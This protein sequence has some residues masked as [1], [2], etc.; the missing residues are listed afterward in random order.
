[1]K[2]ALNER[3]NEIIKSFDDMLKNESARNR[4]YK[5]KEVRAEL[6]RTVAY[7]ERL[8]SMLAK[9]NNETVA[10]G[11][12]QL[13]IKDQQEQFALTEEMYDTVRRRIQE[14]EVERKRPAQISVAY[15]A[16][17]MLAK[18]QRF[19]LVVANIFGGGNAADLMLALMLDR[20]NRKS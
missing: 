1:M 4:D 14:L 12:K 9:H 18:D 10:L 6:E 19:K 20:T 13:A 17:S 7:E 5:L 3:Q 8:N 16:A 2:K 15:T 11:R